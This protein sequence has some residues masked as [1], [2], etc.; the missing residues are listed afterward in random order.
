MKTYDVEQTYDWNYANAPEWDEDIQSRLAASRHVLEQAEATQSYA[1]FPVRT[2]VA[3]AAGPLLNGRW[4]LA[5]A[6]EGFEVVTYKTVRTSA[7]ACYAPPN[8]VAVNS[9]LPPHQGRSLEWVQRSATMH[10]TWAVSFGMPSREPE[11]W[12][13][14]VTWVRENLPPTHYLAV[15]VVGTEQADDSLET[16]A[17]D[18]ASCAVQ[19]CRN[20]ADL[21]ELNFSC[22][23][24]CSSDGQL[25]QDP[26]SA[27]L[28]VETVANQLATQNYRQPIL[29]KI[30]HDADD[31]NLLQLIQAL[32]GVATGCVMTNSLPAVV[33]DEFGTD[34]FE[35]QK[36]GICGQLTRDTSADQV[37]R[38]VRLRDAN[39]SQLKAIGVGGISD[40]HDID[41][42]VAKGAEATQVA[43]AVMIDPDIGRSLGLKGYRSSR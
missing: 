27:G 35:G 26:T 5:L 36:R 30:G 15:S 18:Y 29:V 6:A 7:R 11:V 32:D 40:Q 33:R 16:L 28:V 22:P 14:D 12:Q 39:A 1:G 17:S 42:Y 20:G 3:V 9:P 13:N 10:G 38:F 41:H 24:V 8:L 23:N 25:F 43:T 4:C 37:E 34:L 19:A 21:I 31:E 2:A